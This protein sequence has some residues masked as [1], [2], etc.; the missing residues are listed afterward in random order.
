MDSCASGDF[1][2]AE[3]DWGG[4]MGIGRGGGGE[5][6][7][8]MKVTLLVMTLIFCF[9]DWNYNPQAT[10]RTRRPQDVQQTQRNFVSFCS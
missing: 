1:E 8:G 6:A 7:G 10:L 5:A 2:T 9:V 4:V 3:K